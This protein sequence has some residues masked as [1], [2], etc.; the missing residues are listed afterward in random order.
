M[1]GTESLPWKRNLMS[2]KGD[3]LLK[4]GFSSGIVMGTL[5]GKNLVFPENVKTHEERV[6][7]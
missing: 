7:F 5:P 1:L 4:A 3:V 2:R 6:A